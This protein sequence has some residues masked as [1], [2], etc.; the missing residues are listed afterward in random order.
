VKVAPWW[1]LW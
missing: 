1:N